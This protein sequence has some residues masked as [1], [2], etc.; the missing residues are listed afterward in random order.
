VNPKKICNY[1]FEL[2]TL[3]KFAHSGVKLA[4]VKDPDTIAEHVYRSAIIG[5]VLAK[6]EK[7][8]ASKVAMICL[9][10]DNAECRVTDLHKVARRYI[11]PDEGEI[12]A[13]KEQVSGF[14]PETA[15]E[16][17][18][19]FTE[20]EEAKTKEGIL[21]RDADMLEMAFQAK[22][23]METGYKACQDWIDNVENNIKSKS[24]KTLLKT[25]KKTGF[26]EWWIGLKK[27]VAY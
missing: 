16:L 19:L 23:Y 25:M 22:E 20:F 21:A 11:D 6:M 13:Y 8:D 27:I 3:K 12:K 17:T 1:I 10:H 26:T 2:G 15:K 14:P 24:A 18:N 5:Y 9:F 4:G 7:A